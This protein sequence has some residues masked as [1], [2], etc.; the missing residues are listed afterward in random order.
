MP[1][2]AVPSV[3]SAAPAPAA[4]VAGRDTLL[5]SMAWRLG[6]FGLCLAITVQPFRDPD[7][8]WHLAVGRL[9]GSSGIPSSEPFSFGTAE[10]AWGGQQWLYERLLALL[11]DHGGA[12]AAMAALGIVGA[13]AFV[14]AGLC[15]RPSER[16]GGGWV[17]AATL[18]GCL[19]AG[20]VVGVR[21]QVITVLGTA[22]TLLVVTRWRAGATRAVWALPPLF[23]VWANLHAGFVT[24][25]GI[26]LVAAVVVA[27]HRRLGGHEVAP[28]R[29]LLLALGAGALLTLANPTGPRLYPYIG[30]TFLNPTLT[31]SITEWQS[32]DFHDTWLRL[33]E[34]CAVGLVVLWGVSGRRVDPLDVAL[35]LGTMAATLQAQRNMALFAVVAVPQ[36]AGYGSA[37]WA[38]AR[39]SSGRRALRPLP[40]VLALTAA[41][42]VAAAV[43]VADVA[44]AT[45]AA[46]T[47]RYE[48]QHEPEAAVGWVASHLAGQRLLSTYEWGGYL[49]ERL[50]T[51]PRVVWIY[52]ESAVFGNARLEE[53]TKVLTL[54]HGWQDVIAANGMRHAVLPRT[55]ALT[56]ALVAT[57]WSTLCRDS[58]PDAVVLE[59]PATPPVPG[60]GAGSGTDPTL[61]P[62]C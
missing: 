5:R 28:L 38:R 60:S 21:G 26:V 48:A 31:N 27:F 56:S 23:L 41:A 37:A 9:I 36:L 18:I 14:V 6:A 42:A 59:A 13:L 17:G 24:G 29:P 25:L 61:A 53:Y 40:G 8:W 44:P 12:G 55:A 62:A 34:I 1:A 49:A 15:V 22:I 35:G 30:A 11:V 52:G 3:A 47:A 32:P 2:T 20:S 58:G 7:V 57:G 4:V 19:C 46:T 51:G 39:A 43:V 45:S 54:Q 50:G 10:N 16:I 33:L